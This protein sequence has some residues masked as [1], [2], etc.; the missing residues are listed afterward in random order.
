MT[1][2]VENSAALSLD[3]HA[4]Q[5]P[6]TAALR[7]WIRTHLP[8]LGDGVSYDL[9]LIC[10]ELITNAYEHG[11]MPG[12]VRIESDGR[13]L[14]RVEVDDSSRSMPIMRRLSSDSPRGRGLHMVASLSGRWGAWRTR[15]GKTVWAELATRIS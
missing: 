6:P 7:G 13:K 12:R 10:T 4:R 2:R 15:T 14:I 3:L 9:Q 5:V 8:G 11:S 1:A